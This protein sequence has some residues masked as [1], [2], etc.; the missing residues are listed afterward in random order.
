MECHLD[1]KITTIG[2]ENEQPCDFVLIN[3]KKPSNHRI[4]RF[5]NFNCFIDN[6]KV[7]VSIKISQKTFDDLILKFYSKKWMEFIEFKSKLK[8][9]LLRN[10]GLIYQIIP[11]GD[12]GIYWLHITKELNPIR[13]CKEELVKSGRYDVKKIGVPY[14]N[15]NFIHESV[16]KGKTDWI[17]AK[18]ILLVEDALANILSALEMMEYEKHISLK[19]LEVNTSLYTSNPEIDFEK[20]KLFT[21]YLFGSPVLGG[22]S[23]ENF[24]DYQIC[25]A[26]SKSNPKTKNIKVYKKIRPSDDGKVLGM[27]RAEM[28]LKNVP[29]KSADDINEVA[30]KTR[31]ELLSVTNWLFEC[32]NSKPTISSKVIKAFLPYPELKSRAVIQDKIPNKLKDYFMVIKCAGLN[33][34]NVLKPQYSSLISEV[35]V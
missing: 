16:V 22:K 30:N 12:S 34:A 3:T 29:I 33:P 31:D 21:G 20:L 7:K 18:S 5:A 26:D 35:L 24:I 13:V 27:I 23:A 8:T 15:D 25:K 2:Q 6:S 28:T 19:H 32:L 1:A 11:A 10:D 14:H 17:W 4:F 9:G